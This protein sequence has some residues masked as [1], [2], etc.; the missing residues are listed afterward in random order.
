MTFLVFPSTHKR[1]LVYQ[2]YIHHCYT[3]KRIWFCP[4][5]PGQLLRFF[6]EDKKQK[7]ALLL[8]VV[9]VF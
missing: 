8:T 3:S 2:L 9:V 1:S 6:R 4:R 5:V 7:D